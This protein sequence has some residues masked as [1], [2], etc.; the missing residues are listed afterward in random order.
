MILQKN[1][2]SKNLFAHFFLS[3]PSKNWWDIRQ[4]P[5]QIRP[6]AMVDLQSIFYILGICLLIGLLLIATEI[7]INRNP[8]PGS[9]LNFFRLNKISGLSGQYINIS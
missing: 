9:K 3:F 8:T 7:F 4:E 6:L 5:S 1:A 2:K